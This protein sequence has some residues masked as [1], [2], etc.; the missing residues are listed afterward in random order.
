MI[1]ILEEILGEYTPQTITVGNQ[2]QALQGVASL[3]IPY[4]IRALLFIIVVY[5]TL[6]AI[7]G[8]IK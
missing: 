8:F 3:D 4:I 2:I 1:E 5:C 7:G 6:R